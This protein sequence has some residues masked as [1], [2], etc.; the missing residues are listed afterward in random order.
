MGP[1]CEA[2]NPLM[3]LASACWSFG[4]CCSLRMMKPKRAFPFT[5]WGYPTMADSATAG[6]SLMASSMGAVPRL[7]PETIITSSTRPVIR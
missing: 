4:S 7:C 6:C 3:V 5:S 2:I 1:T